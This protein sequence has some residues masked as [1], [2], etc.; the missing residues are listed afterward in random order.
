MPTTIAIIGDRDVASRPH[1]A[2]EASLCHAAE[3]AGVEL[4][5]EWLPTESLDGEDA[6]RRLSRF[7]GL[8]IAPGSPYR[9]LTGALQAIR[10]AREHDR[11]L[12]GTCGG[13]Q[14]VVLEFARH[15]LGLND[16][17]HAEYDP[18]A[19]V[20]FVAPLTCSLVGR[21]MSVRINPGS[22][23]ADVL[24]ADAIAA[25]YYCNFGLNP[26]FRDRLD[27]AGLRI[28]GE[29]EHGEARIVE[30]PG[31]RFFVAT[32]FLPQFDS[33]TDR[34]HPLIATFVNAAS[35]IHRPLHQM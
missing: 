5:F 35:K 30:L 27:A 34:P 31:H 7:A 24:Q 2:T 21:T 20:L 22:R 25:Q 19:S 13:F 33:T 11:P 16:A 10:F 1:A 12:I 18:Y 3:H 28:V 15:V 23:V 14:H 8:W 4:D 32:L 9:S 29:D 17:Q 6:E 26:A